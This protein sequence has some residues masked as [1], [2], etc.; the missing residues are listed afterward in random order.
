MSDNSTV[1]P[2]VRAHSAEGFLAALGLLALADGAQPGSQLRFTSKDEAAEIRPPI[3][4]DSF[5]EHVEGLVMA[6]TNPAPMPEIGALVRVDKWR[7]AQEEL[8][9]RQTGT[10]PLL[11]LVCADEPKTYGGKKVSP[12]EIDEHK[13]A[14]ERY[15]EAHG[16][17]KATRKKLKGL[18][19]SD[20][21]GKRRADRRAAERE[22]LEPQ[23]RFQSA[24]VDEL[25][26]SLVDAGVSFN[27][28]TGGMESIEVK[29]FSTSEMLFLNRIAKVGTVM[30]NVGKRLQEPGWRPAIDNIQRSVMGG[31]LLNLTP[32][33]DEVGPQAVAP[34]FE[35]LALI[36]ITFYPPRTKPLVWRPWTRYVGVDAARVLVTDSSYLSG[37]GWEGLTSLGRHEAEVTSKG[38]DHCF[39]AISKKESQ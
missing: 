37:R 13:A 15:T 38:R 12:R 14:A 5:Q 2:A 6:W 10:T 9:G 31:T 26:R 20:A 17:L 35:L 8:W 39:S 24:T 18:E 19:K 4:P 25:K 23:E 34:I 22:L 32:G 11:R 27:E 3:D 1:M 16:E 30:A 33:A 29:A 36:G 28:N 21:A 7:S